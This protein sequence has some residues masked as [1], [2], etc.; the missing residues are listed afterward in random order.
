MQHGEEHGLNGHQ[1]YGSRRGKSTYDTLITVRVIYD[2][3]RV[4]RDY[5]VSIFNNLKGCYDRVRPSVN[6]I[7]TR[8]MGLPKNFAVCNAA[9]LRKMKHFIRTGFGISQGHLQ[10]DE[11]NNA[12]GLRQDNGVDYC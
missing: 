11:E 1:L 4:Q 10:W 3:A 7:T 9:T 8:R 5:I 12:G 6:T 2:R